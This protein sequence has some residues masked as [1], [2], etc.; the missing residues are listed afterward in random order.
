M[1]RSIACVRSWY[2]SVGNDDLAFDNRLIA[3][4]SRAA[5][6]GAGRSNSKAEGVSGREHVVLLIQHSQEQLKK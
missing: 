6:L 3:S 2:A 5:S 4:A 1:K